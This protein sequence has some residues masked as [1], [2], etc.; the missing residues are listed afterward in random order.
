MSFKKT[1]CRIQISQFSSLASI[2]RRGIPSGRSS[3][4]ASSV[5]MTRIFRSDAHQCLEASNCSRL[6]SSERNGKS[7][8]HYSEFEKNP[9][10]KCILPDDVTIPSGRHSVFDK[11][12]G[13]LSQTQ[14]W[15]ENCN[16]L[17]DVVFLSGC[18]P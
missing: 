13:F 5:W 11:V 14:I 18:Y 2:G 10:F 17:D 6:H 16:R 1:L 7:S 3:V 12:I 8:R 9:A 15:E 4:K